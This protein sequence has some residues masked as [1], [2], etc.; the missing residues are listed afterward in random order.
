[1]CID[2]REL[3]KLTVKNRYPLPRIDDLFD[4]LQGS[5]VYSKIDLR[6]GYHQLRVREEDIPKTAFRTR[7]GHYEFQ[8]MPFGLTNAPAVFMDLMN[9]VCKPFLDKFVIVFIDDILIYS[10]NKKEHE[11]HL[12]AILEL[13]KKEE[14][15]AKFSKCEFWLPKVQFLGHVI[16]S[17]GI[18]VDPAKIESIKDWA[19]PKTPT[20]IR[21]FLGLNGY[22]RRFIKGFSKIANPRTSLLREASEAKILSYIAMLQSKVLGVVL[23]HIEKVF[24]MHHGQLKIVRKKTFTTHDL[25]LD[26]KSLQ[27]ILDQKELNMRQRRWLELL[28]DY[29]CEIRYHPGKANVVADALSRKEQNKPLRV[30]ALVMT[31]SWNLDYWFNLPK[32]I[33]EAQIEAQK[34]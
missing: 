9:R 25:E 18:H 24:V 7:Y 11:E 5:S 26:H 13:L 4:Q 2:Y 31:I 22:Y 19:S 3:N 34:L 14:L 16:D 33:L 15:Y 21:Q 20:E 28:S 17:Q 1:M 12:K 8:V 6:S 32:Q 29:D 10:K 23:M 30:R 27:H